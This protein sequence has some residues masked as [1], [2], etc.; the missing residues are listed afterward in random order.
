[1]K[2]FFSLILA[3]LMLSCTK[4]STDLIL[5]GSVE[6]INKRLMNGLD[7]NELTKDSI[8]LLAFAIKENKVEA[9]SLLFGNGAVLLGTEP[10]NVIDYALK[11][12]NRKMVGAL[13]KHKRD[14]SKEE[15]LRVVDA[16]IENDWINVFKLISDSLSLIKK[17]E[18]GNILDTYNSPKIREFINS[19]IEDLWPIDNSTIS[20]EM[21][22]HEGL[23]FKSALKNFSSEELGIENISLVG[24]DNQMVVKLSSK[25]NFKSKVE[26]FLTNPNR[27]QDSWYSALKNSYFNS[28]VVPLPNFIPRLYSHDGFYTLED[29]GDVLLKK[30]LVSF[31]I[32]RI[33]RNSHVISWLWKSWKEA[34]FDNLSTEQYVNSDYCKTT[35]A[36]IETWE[37]ISNK[38]NFEKH[39]SSFFDSVSNSNGYEWYSVIPDELQAWHN[40]DLG[41]SEDWA[42]SFWMRRFKEKNHNVVISILKEIDE[43][44]KNDGSIEEYKKTKKLNEARDEFISRANCCHDIYNIKKTVNIGADISGIYNING[45][46]PIHVALLTNNLELVE[47]L[48]TD[49]IEEI[50][51]SLDK[52]ENIYSYVTSCEA[53]DILFSYDIPIESSRKYAATP[54]NVFIHEKRADLIACII[55]KGFSVKAPKKYGG[56]YFIDIN[57]E[58]PSEKEKEMVKVLLDNGADPRIVDGY[59]ERRPIDIAHSEIKEMMLRAVDE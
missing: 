9:A 32:H 47:N 35:E 17:M 43:N 46:Q 22:T 58:N 51:L 34:I 53:I 33:N 56:S 40:D 12:K 15:T 48:L 44:Y 14:L 45:I 13:L 37:Y 57:I 11:F 28:I 30:Q 52:G 26:T 20:K 24:N 3:L 8:S 2:Y 16:A 39:L 38:E 59:P 1:M 25:D 18:I 10:D 42:I 6:E 41:V 27:D 7:Q 31:L 21:N 29:E 55:E 49:S 4:N 54:I 19:Q 5:S 50:R 36:L 23:R